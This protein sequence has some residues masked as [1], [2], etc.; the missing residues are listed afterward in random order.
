MHERKAHK[1]HGGCCGEWQRQEGGSGRGEEEDRRCS[2]TAAGARGARV[3]LAP[4]ATSN[5]A[6]TSD[7]KAKFIAFVERL[8]QAENR[9]SDAARAQ[10]ETVTL[11]PLDGG[12]AMDRALAT[13][14]GYCGLHGHGCP[15][16]PAFCAQQAE[17]D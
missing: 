10:T 16:D 12:R 3:V 2:G 4:Q 5:A 11:A 8:P 13:V 17:V 1:T 9:F 15:D 14:D 7:A 6:R